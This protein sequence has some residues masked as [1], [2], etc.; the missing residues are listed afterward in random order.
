MARLTRLVVL[1]FVLSGAVADRLAAQVTVPGNW[2]LQVGTTGGLGGGGV[3]GVSI[4]SQG[5]VTCSASPTRC[6]ERL[7]GEALRSLTEAVGQALLVPWVGSTGP[8]LDCYVTRLT[9]RHRQPD[10]TETTY[11]ASWDQTTQAAISAELKRIYDLAM[12]SR[13]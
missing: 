2:V 11:A 1:V 5:Q 13:R 4:T 3:G 9:L 12:A 7:S 10:G 6:V 8:C